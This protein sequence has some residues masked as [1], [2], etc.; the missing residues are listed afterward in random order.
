VKAFRIVGLSL[1]IDGSF[2]NEISMKGIDNN[3]FIEGIKE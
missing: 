1:P 3:I 2:D